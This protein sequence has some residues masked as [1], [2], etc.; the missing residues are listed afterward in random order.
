MSDNEQNSPQE[1]KTNPELEK[2]R[3]QVSDKGYDPNELAVFFLGG[4]EMVIGEVK[5]IYEGALVGSTVG[6][7]NPKR[8][9]RLQQ[10]SGQGIAITLFVGDLDCVDE[11]TMWVNVPAAYWVRETSERAQIE[12]LKLIMQYFNQRALSRA[13]EAGIE[14]PTIS[15]I[16]R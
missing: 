7:R 3:S 11:G 14:L 15:R 1:S 6:I 8:Y 13:A 16:K 9:M 4:S 2:L 12:T 10:V 5:D